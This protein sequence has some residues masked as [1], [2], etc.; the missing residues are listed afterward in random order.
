MN[1]YTLLCDNYTLINRLEIVLC[2]T[3]LSIE[4]EILLLQLNIVVIKV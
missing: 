3:M 2:Q 1:T 4:I